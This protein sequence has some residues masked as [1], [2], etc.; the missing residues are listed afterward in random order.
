MD[1]SAF[2]MAGSPTLLINGVD[3]FTTANHAV[4]G[5]ACRV[6]R[7]E[8]DEPVAV[9]SVAQLRDA[10][11]A[12]GTTDQPDD[13]LSA[14]R[15]RAV[16]LDPVERAEQA[17][18]L[19]TELFGALLRSRFVR[20]TSTGWRAPVL[21]GGVEFRCPGPDVGVGAEAAV[22]TFEAE[23]AEQAAVLV[24]DRES[25]S[26]GAGHGPVN[27]LEPGTWR[28]DPAGEPTDLASQHVRGCGGQVGPL[29]DGQQNTAFND[30]QRVDVIVRKCVTGLAHR[31][32]GV[33]ELGETDHR[34]G[35]RA[36]VGRRRVV[37]V[38]AAHDDR[39]VTRWIVTTGEAMTVT[40]ASTHGP[41]DVGPGRPLLSQKHVFDIC[42]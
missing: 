5:L 32:R 38:D 3:P 8:N 11:A 23:Q 42:L 36:T 2:G 40:A 9:P 33:G 14:W 37:G 39:S 30:Q 21:A 31:C 29:D 4:G 41:T 22:G 18:T 17:E 15:A 24:D 34:V 27:G 1:A 13:V 28:D 7:D 6:Y 35:H 25:A 26:A 19:A 20:P 16:P 12:A 10:I